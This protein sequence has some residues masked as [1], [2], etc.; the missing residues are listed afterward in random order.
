MVADFHYYDHEL[1]CLDLIKHSIVA[2][3]YSIVRLFC[4]EFL[5]AGWEGVF[6]QAIDVS[7]Q[8]LLDGPVKG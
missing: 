7:L 8:P 5:G 6:S 1:V 3:A 2:Y 4:M